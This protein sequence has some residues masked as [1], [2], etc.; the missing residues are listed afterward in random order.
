RLRGARQDL[1][2]L[3]SRA[4][5]RVAAAVAERRRRLAEANRA[6]EALHPRT[7]LVARRAELAA[8]SARAEG[9]VR[10]RLHD[11]ARRFGALGARLDTLSPL[12]VLERG[13]ALARV[14]DHVVTA[15]D[16]VTPGDALRVVLRRGAL[17][18]RVERV[19]PERDEKEE[20]EEKA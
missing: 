3:E 14:G 4:R 12:R 1:D 19:E 15:A 9:A 17:D 8:L 2:H 18:C 6:L 11:E 20:K 5:H 13:Y 7:R 10:R 16:E